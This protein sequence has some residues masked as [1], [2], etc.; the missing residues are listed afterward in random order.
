MAKR[1]SHDSFSGEARASRRV[2][3]LAWRDANRSSLLG[4]AV[5]PR[6]M[7]FGGTTITRSTTLLFSMAC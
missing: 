6:M 2:A 5:E 1:Y 7:S 4:P 3:R